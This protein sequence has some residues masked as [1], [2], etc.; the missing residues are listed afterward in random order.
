MINAVI[1]NDAGQIT[2]LHRRNPHLM[3]GIFP[4][5]SLLCSP[6]QCSK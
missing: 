5:L 4:L 2:D 3:E 6:S 1:P